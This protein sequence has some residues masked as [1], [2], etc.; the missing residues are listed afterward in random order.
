[1]IRTT[2][3]EKIDSINSFTSDLFLRLP[4]CILRILINDKDEQIEQ[5]KYYKK[6]NLQ[7]FF[8]L[9]PSV[10]FLFIF[11]DI[12]KKPPNK[13]KEGEGDCYSDMEKNH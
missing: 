9:S 4:D 13:R 7:F 10:V 6:H 11:V 8:S 5:K 1:M 3:E 2:G 12:S